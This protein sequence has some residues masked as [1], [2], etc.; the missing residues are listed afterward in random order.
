M[1]IKREIMA[2]A[3]RLIFFGISQGIHCWSDTLLF[4]SLQNSECG[5]RPES[6]RLNPDKSL[7]NFLPCYSSNSRNLLQF[8]QFS[9]CSLYRRKEENMIENNTPENY[10]YPH[11]YGLRNP[12]RKVRSKNSHDYAQKPQ[13]I[14]TFL[15]SAS[16][17]NT[18]NA[19]LNKV[20]F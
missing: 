13:R 10:L 9:Y 6:G 20:L 16:G 2:T 3:R 7:K 18:V 14:C 15:N 8:L 17:Y 1:W 19:D 12:Y 11:L 4:S 5:W